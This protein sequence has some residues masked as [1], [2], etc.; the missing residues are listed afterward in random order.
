ME[1]IVTPTSTSG[2]VINMSNQ[3]DNYGWNMP[4]LASANSTFYAQLHSSANGVDNG[5]SSSF[6][7]N[8]KYHLIL[9]WDYDANASDRVF[10]LYVNNVLI[11]QKNNITYQSSGASNY[12]S[13]EKTILDVVMILMV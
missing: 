8:Q 13:L 5:I 3:L 9:T 4:P 6:N 7:L 1:V 12:F 2:N 11:G 10:K